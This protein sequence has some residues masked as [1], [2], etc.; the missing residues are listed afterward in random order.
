[1]TSGSPDG[2]QGLSS[3]ASSFI[4]ATKRPPWA[5]GRPPWAMERPPPPCGK[6]INKGC[7]GCFGSQPHPLNTALFF[8]SLQAT[9]DEKGKIL[10][11]I[12]LIWY[13]RV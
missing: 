3:V 6:K 11:S 12:S 10:E 9:T 8:L 2:W 4:S 13:G 5:M 1:M 7:Q